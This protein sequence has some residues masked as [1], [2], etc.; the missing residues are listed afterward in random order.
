MDCADQV[1][2]YQCD[3][4]ASRLAVIACAI[5]ME[6]MAIVANASRYDGRCMK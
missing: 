6:M 3:K 4:L 1:G 5:L 2:E